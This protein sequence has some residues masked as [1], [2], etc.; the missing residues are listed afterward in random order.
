MSEFPCDAAL[1]LIL[2]GVGGS[3]KNKIQ[4]MLMKQSFG[5]GSVKV[6]T[7]VSA[8]TRLP[9][10]K[11]NEKEGIDY[12]FMSDVEFRVRI[13][14]GDFVEHVYNSNRTRYGLLKSEVSKAPKGCLAITHLNIDGAV[15]LRTLCPRT[16][17]V[18]VVSH[19][20]PDKNLLLCEDRMR[21]RGDREQDIKARIELG[22]KETE[23]LRDL[24]ANKTFDFVAVNSDRA[25]QDAVAVIMPEIERA[26]GRV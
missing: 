26:L 16:L 20:N 11:D 9:R 2:T 3:G 14:R 12:Y 8:T 24:L 7:F 4:E 19:L 22:R 1:I 13:A 10:E 5:N 18:W 6:H 25:L 15:A 23:L 17:L 21:A